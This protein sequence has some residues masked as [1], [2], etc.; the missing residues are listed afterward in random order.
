[1]DVA[2][3]ARTAPGG[4]PVAE[5]TAV[6]SLAVRPVAVIA[7]CLGIF[8]V[9]TAQRWGYNGDELYFLAAARHLDWGYADQPP[10]LPLLARITGDSLLT[11][12]LPAI[13]LATAGVFTPA[14]IT[15]ELGGTRRAQVI[16]AGTYAVS[17]QALMYGDLML[18]RSVD[19]FLWP[20]AI[21]LL[22]RWVRLRDDWALLGAGLAVAVGLQAKYLIVV[23]CAAC[24]GCVALVGPREML[25]RPLLWLGVALA[26]LSALPSALWQYWH[27]WP[28]WGMPGVVAR[29]AADVG[30][31]AFFLPLTALAAGTLAGVVLAG[32]GLWRLMRAPELR[33]Y[34]FLGYACVTVAVVFLVLGGR[35][36]YCS[37]LFPVLWGSALTDDQPRW[38][39]AW[40]SYALSAASMIMLTLVAPLPFGLHDEGLVANDSASW[41]ELADTVTGA[42]RSLPPGLRRG[43]IVVTEHYWQ[44]SAL[45]RFGHGLLP[46]YSPHRGYWYFGRP[47]DNSGAV[48]VVGDAPGALR[49][50]LGRPRRIATRGGELGLA[51]IN[52]DVSVWLYTD[53]HPP[54]SRLWPLLRRL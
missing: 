15:R 34:R 47:P 14:L 22:V 1:M 54:W 17:P 41:P 27:G 21:W 37:G 38:L 49:R 30:G 12:R 24:L 29:E 40:P 7:C 26:L 11:L 35:Y 25:R 51:G 20:V 42:Y 36:Y 9:A 31:R 4:E 32:R 53:P 13:A 45:E 33:G 44:A 43:A 18:T 39:L 52:K 8:L 2:R 48:L 50:Y 6:P 10:M 19:V 28:Q 23:L 5:E 46:V 16:A 3:I